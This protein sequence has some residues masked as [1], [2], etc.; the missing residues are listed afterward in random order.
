MVNQGILTHNDALNRCA[1][2]AVVCICCVLPAGFVVPAFGAADEHLNGRVEQIIDGDSL[3]IDVGGHRLE[4]RLWGID[5]PEYDQPG[6]QTAASAL[7]R[8]AYGKSVRLQIRYQDR[9]G[10]SV[11]EMYQSGSNINELMVSGGYSWVHHYFCTEPVCRR[12]KQ[13]E[14]AARHKRLGIWSSDNPIPPWQ[15]KRRG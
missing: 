13:F 5:S 10:R 8:F 7:H 9:Y 12:W 11:A 4:V 1:C 3:I 6:A 14:E 2:V 15:W